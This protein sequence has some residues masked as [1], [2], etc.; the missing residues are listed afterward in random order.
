[1]LRLVTRRLLL[2]VLT[3]FIV[4]LMVFAGVELL[5]GDLATAYLCR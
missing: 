4:S 2:S 5:P 3:L 1:M